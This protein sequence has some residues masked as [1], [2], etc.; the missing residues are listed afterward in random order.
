[1]R[2]DSRATTDVMAILVRIASYR[3]SELLPTLRNCIAKARWPRD[4]R[5]ALCW[6]HDGTESLGPYAEDR[7][8]RIVDVPYRESRGAGWARSLSAGLYE[9]EAFTLSL[10]SHHR[11]AEGWDERLL[12]MM[13]D[14]GSAKPILTSYPPAYRPGDEA[15]YEIWPNSLEFGHFSEGGMIT[16]MPVAIPDHAS[17]RRPIRSR[18]YA[19]GFAFSIGRLVEEVPPDPE[20]YFLGEEDNMGVRAFTHG[21]DLFCPHRVVCWHEYGR[22]DKPKHWDDHTDE[23]D[24]ASSWSRLE[25]RGQAR[26]RRLF[27]LDPPDPAED[28]GPFGFGSVRSLRDYETYAGLSFRLRAVQAHTLDRLPPPSPELF[29]TEAAWEGSLLRPDSSVVPA[30]RN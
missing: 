26:F 5:F 2:R 29:G 6:Q 14:A 3:D 15:S 19:A 16:R 13:A 27:G 23:A 20:I 9:G 1:V 22:A 28:F 24:A 10:D 21:Y 7:R 25:R 30:R 8:F 12:G 4:L 11:F 17:L 18:F